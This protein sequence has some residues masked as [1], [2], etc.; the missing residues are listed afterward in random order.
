MYVFPQRSDRCDSVHP[1]H[2]H[3]PPSPPASDSRVS[4]PSVQLSPAIPSHLTFPI[5]LPQIGLSLLQ[6]VRHFQ[7]VPFYHKTL[8]PFFLSNSTSS[9]RPS[10]HLHYL[11][12]LFTLLPHVLLPFE[13]STHAA[14]PSSSHGYHFHVARDS[15][16]QPLGIL[17]TSLSCTYKTPPRSQSSCKIH[18]PL[19]T[20]LP[21][22]PPSAPTLYIMAVKAIIPST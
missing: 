8:S 21:G 20:K 4:L 14:T 9:A 15:P 3:S 22:P 16:S 19:P 1:L 2:L 13:L 5:Q 11:L 12:Q 18:S 10:S 7:T 17:H 6:S